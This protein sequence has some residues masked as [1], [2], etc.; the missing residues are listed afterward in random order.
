MKEILGGGGAFQVSPGDITPLTRE[1]KYLREAFGE[2]FMWYPC[3]G[4]HDHHEAEDI[5]FSHSYFDRKLADHVNPGPAGC[6]KTTYSWDF[7]N[8][9]FIVLNLY[10]D[11]KDEY[12]TDGDVVDELYEWLK[13]DL[14][15]NK[16]PAVFVF[17]HEP[18]FPFYR[19]RWS[20]LNRYKA[21]RD[22]FWKLLEDN[23][24]AAY[25]C[26]HTHKPAVYRENEGKTWQ[27]Q[28]GEARGR[29]NRKEDA[30]VN[31]IVRK[32]EVEFQLFT[33][34]NRDGNYVILHNWTHPLPQ[35]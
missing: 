9:H 22:R 16:K 35:K 13:A 19:Q 20:S 18:A 11:G 3:Q 32:D 31:V 5:E 24:V 2:D 1:Y 10:F 29:K 4:N 15:K 30:F 7:K 33:N 12:G 14:E 27:V 26:G 21:H 8:A 34:E 25:F 17:G 28:C 6:E 23:G